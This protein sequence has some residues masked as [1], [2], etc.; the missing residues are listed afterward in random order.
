MTNVWGEGYGDARL[1]RFGTIQYKYESYHI[2]SHSI[3]ISY[4]QGPTGSHT[5]NDRST[6]VSR[7]LVSVI[8]SA[9]CPF[10]ITAVNSFLY[11]HMTEYFA[12]KHC[13]SIHSR[14]RRRRGRKHAMSPLRCPLAGRSTTRPTA[15]PISSTAQRALCSGRGLLLLRCPTAGQSSKRRTAACASST[16]K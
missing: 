10:R 4:P 1:L 8:G 2:T 9:R 15:G 11:L 3:T 16:V 12:P 14:G 5:Q 6:K 13:P 7:Y